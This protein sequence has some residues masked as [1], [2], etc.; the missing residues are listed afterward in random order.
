MVF[1][2]E[3][4]SSSSCTNASQEHGELVRERTDWGKCSRV[5]PRID[6]TN[7]DSNK[8]VFHFVSKSPWSRTRACTR[9]L[10]GRSSAPHR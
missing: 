8:Q 1:K 4:V 7:S 6:P 10:Q 5:A 2:K 3:P 9:S